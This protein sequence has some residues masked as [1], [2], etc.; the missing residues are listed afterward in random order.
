MGVRRTVSPRATTLAPRNG[1]SAR[2]VTSAADDCKE[3]AEL[4]AV[5]TEVGAKL[6]RMR[7]LW[8]RILQSIAIDKLSTECE[9][10]DDADPEKEGCIVQHSVGNVYV[11]LF[12][13][14]VSETRP[15]RIVLNGD[16]IPSPE[17]SAQVESLNSALAARIPLIDDEGRPVTIEN[18][19]DEGQVRALFQAIA[20]TTKNAIVRPVPRWVYDVANS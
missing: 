3:L 8:G 6:G 12:S 5:P 13:I 7:R 10:R 20:S 17:L 19:P 14:V 4:L 15:P 9:I 1:K 18:I 16:T 2:E 11:P